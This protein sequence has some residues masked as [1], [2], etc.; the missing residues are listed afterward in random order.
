MLT[1]RRKKRSV[2][3]R[4]KALTANQ[5]K[6]K[7][8]TE[9]ACQTDMESSEQNDEVK[10]L[11]LD[12]KSNMITKQELN[13]TLEL[14]ISDM[15]KVLATKKEVEVVS[16]KVRGMNTRL[17]V[18]EGVSSKMVSKVQKVDQSMLKLHETNQALSQ[19]VSE[20]EETQKQDRLMSENE[21]IS[22][23][24]AI[25]TEHEDHIIQSGR[26]EELERLVQEL[27]IE[28]VEVSK[29]I[30]EQVSNDVYQEVKRKCDLDVG[31][32]SGH[33][34]E[35]LNYW[36]DLSV[37]VYGLF[38]N[39]NYDDRDHVIAIGRIIGVDLTYSDLAIVNRLGAEDKLGH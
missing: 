5:V 8:K 23:H 4:R 27:K 37:I 25:S 34:T 14:R 28:K 10:L 39:R 21:Y 18:V 36:P 29:D 16:E 17:E 33:D 12:I 19:K 9:E 13:D 31:K 24:T 3:Y 6:S 22:V 30:I 1:Q 38:E 11:L 15:V 20:L 32:S 26:I 7:S 2:D 35:K